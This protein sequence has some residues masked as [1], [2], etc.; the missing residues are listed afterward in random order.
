MI[1]VLSHPTSQPEMRIKLE[2]NLPELVTNW[3]KP[4]YANEFTV[5]K[6]FN[7]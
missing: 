7:I 5:T 3:T 1:N 4:F 6:T 2:F